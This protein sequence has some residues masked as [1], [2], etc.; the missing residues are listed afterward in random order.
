MHWDRVRPVCPGKIKDGVFRVNAAPSQNGSI[1]QPTQDAR[2]HI[3]RT[4]RKEGLDETQ[5]EA[6]VKK[7]DDGPEDER[8]EL[9]PGLAAT[10]GQINGVEPALVGPFLSHRLLLK[11][12]LE[13]TACHLGARAYDGQLT[14]TKMALLERSPETAIYTIEELTSR[15]YQPL[16]CLALTG[17]TPHA[18]VII[19]LLGWSVYRVHLRQIAVPSTNSRYTCYLTTG[20]E[21]FEILNEE[22]GAQSECGR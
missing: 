5:I 13:F 16:H 2:T 9:A 15:R 17:M 8:I 22:G 14:A 6:V 7:F 21:D 18:T 1:I 10:K 3:E 4:L 19:S 12:A 11:I 20:H